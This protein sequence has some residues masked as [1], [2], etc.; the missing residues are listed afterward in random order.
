MDYV[1]RY[2]GGLGPSRT[3]AMC[4][5]NRYRQAR[6]LRTLLTEATGIEASVRRSAAL[7]QSVPFIELPGAHTVK[8]AY[9]HMKDD[10]DAVW[11]TL[12]PA[13]TLGQARTLYTDH[14][15]VERLLALRERSWELRPNFH[16]G[17]IQSGLARTP[18]E[19]AVEDYIKLWQSEI[20]S[21][22]SIPSEAW[23]RYLDWLI[24]KRVAADGYQETFDRAFTD[25][26]R[27]SATPRPG[28]RLV[29]S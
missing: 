9:L 26:D 27:E 21:S 25:T 3:L 15:A 5:G 18:S 6:R 4:R 14:A 12:F 2:F 19:L 16:F 24:E 7:E 17:F 22:V 1:E 29:H 23:P 11:L 13:D 8:T 28:L 10:E 20:G